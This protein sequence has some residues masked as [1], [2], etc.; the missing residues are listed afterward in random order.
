MNYS[1]V[2]FLFVLLLVVGIIAVTARIAL[3]GNMAVITRI[4]SNLRERL[5]NSRLLKMLGLRGI[6]MQDYMQRSETADV[7]AQIGVCNA[8]PE[9]QRCDAVLANPEGG[10]ENLSFCPNAPALE[11]LEQTDCGKS[12]PVVTN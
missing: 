1:L 2:G 3:T 11:K 4:R 8:C 5:G 9:T 10:A 12:E 7:Q 6:S